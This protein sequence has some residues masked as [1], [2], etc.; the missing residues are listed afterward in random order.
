MEVKLYQG[1]LE[2]NWNLL[3]SAITVLVLY[4]IL[5]HF[6]FEK[7]HNF[8]EARK[9]AVQAS[10]DQEA[11]NEEAQTL[12]ADYRTTLANAETEKR[13]II[14]AAKAEADQRADVIVGDAKQQAQKIIAEAHEKMQADEEKAVVQLKKEVASLAVLTAERIMQK[15]VDENSQQELV[16]QVLEEVASGKWQNQ[17][18]R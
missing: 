12:L 9:A 17:S 8:M 10:L 14:K 13:A 1:L 5:K 2:I 6:F 11:A 18:Y 7:V 3:F 15:E 16:D 4:L